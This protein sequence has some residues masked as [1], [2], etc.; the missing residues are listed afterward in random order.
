[1]AAF[2][3]WEAP[4]EKVGLP[5]PGSLP[6][7][8]FELFAALGIPVAQW[9]IAEAPDFAHRVPYPVAVKRLEEHKTERGGVLLGL[10]DKKAFDAAVGKLDADRVLVQR[11]ESGLA[12]AIVGYRDD[13]VVGPLVLVGAG[14]VLA[15]IY[16][17]RVLRMAP[18]SEEEAGDMIERVKGLAA[19]R[20]YRNLPR[21]DLKALARAVSALSRLAL[22]TGRPVREAEINPLLV[23]A[24][25]VVAVDALVAPKEAA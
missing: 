17:D 12:E 14:G 7:N 22:V 13:A 8:P 16:R 18:V 21:G 23:R 6:E 4:R 24:D 1:L 25:G 10:G 9:A 20:G 3:A 2:F 11:M 19:I 5:A 15:E